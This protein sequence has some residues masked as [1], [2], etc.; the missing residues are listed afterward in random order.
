MICLTI[1]RRIFLGLFA[2]IILFVVAMN[3]AMQ[4]FL[5]DIANKDILL[6]LDRSVKAYQQFDEQRGELLTMQ[7]RSIAQ[8]AYLK[9]T[10][11]I[12]DVDADTVHFTALNLNELVR[13]PLLLIVNEEGELMADANRKDNRSLNLRAQPGME[14]AV[15]GEP[16][17]GIWRYGERF[18]RTAIFPV[19]VAGQIVGLVVTGQRLD[20]VNEIGKLGEVTGSDAVLMFGDQSIPAGPVITCGSSGP[21]VFAASSNSGD[22]GIIVGQSSGVNLLLETIGDRST[23]CASLPLGEIEGRLV[24]HRPA[25]EKPGLGDPIQLIMLVSSGI[26]LLRVMIES[27]V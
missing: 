5:K 26:A 18:F 6:G 12:P 20:D 21:S 9:A 16:Y 7:A 11:T 22:K 17:Y 2:V 15:H 1:R 19:D 23:F 10:L 3:I 24:L 8:T 27:G 4:F 14:R 13:H 25:Y